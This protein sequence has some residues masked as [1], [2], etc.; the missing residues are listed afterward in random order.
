MGGGGDKEGMGRGVG[1]ED[2][3]VVEEKEGRSRVD[4]WVRSGERG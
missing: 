2:E 4:E 3:W 1:R